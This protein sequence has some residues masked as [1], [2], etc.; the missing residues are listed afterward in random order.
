MTELEKAKKKWWYD[1]NYDKGANHWD[2]SILLNEFEE[3]WKAA[4]E[5]VLTNKKPIKYKDYKFDYIKT[6]VIKRELNGETD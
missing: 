2:T 6:N 4:L 5:W 3:G 1:H